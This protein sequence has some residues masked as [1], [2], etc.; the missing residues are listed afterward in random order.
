MLLLVTTGYSGVVDGT[1]VH[2]SAIGGTKGT[3]G[4]CGVIGV[5]GD[6]WE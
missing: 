3:G 5:P 2:W 6:T 4:H 1:E